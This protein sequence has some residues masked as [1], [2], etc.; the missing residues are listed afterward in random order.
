MLTIRRSEDR[1]H[2]RHGWLE[3]RHTFSFADYFDPRHMGFGDLRVINEDRVKPGA[4][5]G[6]HAHRDMEILTYVLDGA[7]EHRDSMGNGS[8]I[9]PGDVQLMSAGTGVRHSEYNASDSEEVHFL[10][11]WIIP[12]KPGGA[13]R[14]GQRHYPPEDR[15]GRLQRVA[16]ADGAE[17]SLQIRQD[18]TLHATVLEGDD[19]VRHDVQPGRLAWV[20]V[21]RGRLAIGE[22]ELGAG[23]ALATDEPQTLELRPLSAEPAE[24]LVFDLNGARR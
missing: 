10:Q 12:E 6:T 13:P 20:H 22:H 1:G 14:Y 19:V 11:I 21:A 7:L 17:G 16:S 23:D 2:A 24:V 5:F 15:R 8:V 9:R 4:G 3:S 18:L